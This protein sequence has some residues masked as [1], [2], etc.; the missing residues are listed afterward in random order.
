MIYSL[1]RD[2]WALP[3]GPG[4]GVDR[5]PIPLIQS[6]EN[7]YGAYLS[8]DGRWVAYVSNESGSPEIYVQGVN[9][10]S[11][12]GGKWMVSKGALGLARWRADG[13]ELLYVGAD[14]GLMAIALNG[15]PVFQPS[16][17]QLLFK[18]PPE[19]LRLSSNPGGLA[20]V[21]RDNQ[22]ILLSI[23]TQESARQA[24]SVVLNW[25]AGLAK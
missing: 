8:P 10:S 2:L 25:Q 5:K 24:L 17:P 16:P 1:N 15:G 11:P 9:L 19:F 4:T 22:K 7:K 20:D 21:S 13:K 23:P 3:V 6:P 14:G 18:L 12:N